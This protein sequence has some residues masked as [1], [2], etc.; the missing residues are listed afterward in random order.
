MV[1]AP[2]VV[3][4]LEKKYRPRHGRGEPVEAV[5]GVSFEVR[6]GE[7][8][9]LLGP[10]GAGKSTTINCI[11]GLY[12]ASRGEVRINGLNVHTS[13]KAA[14]RRL[15]V[16]QQEDCLDTDFS[17][18]DQLIRHAAFFRVPTSEGGRRADYL[19]ERFQ[20]AEKASELV[21]ALSGG[22]RRRL[23][24][25]RALISE[26]HVLVLDEPTTGL[27]P[28]ARRVLWDVIVEYRKKGTAILLSTH[29]MDEAERLCDRIAILHQG[30]ILSLAPPEALIVE[31]M[32]KQEVQE[33]VR[34]GVVWRRP[35]NL[36]DVFLKLTGR[37]LTAGGPG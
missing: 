27:D 19:L 1:G 16:C 23:Q 31:H 18:R 7:C 32:G 33:E 14:R 35:P 3:D 10:N 11:T 9:G 26:P 21:E 20:L 2:L 13:P 36:E 22:M 8:F 6:A 5:R 34:P 24:V 17:A 28:E 15:G 12:P 29:Y 30:K 37:K 4:S 25:A